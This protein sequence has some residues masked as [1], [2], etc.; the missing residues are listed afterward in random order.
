[1]GHR[2]HRRSRPDGSA[3]TSG[4]PRRCPPREPARPRL[5]R[6]R[7]R[8]L[9]GRTDHPG[10]RDRRPRA[11]GAH[12]QPRRRRLRRQR[13]RRRPRAGELHTRSDVAG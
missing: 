13:R 12:D 6:G 2:D 11:A 9:S 8:R 1:M 5:D 7:A 4:C 10:L 3:R